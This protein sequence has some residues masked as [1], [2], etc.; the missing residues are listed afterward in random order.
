MD[1]PAVLEAPPAA[2]LAG[3]CRCTYVARFDGGRYDLVPDGCIDLLWRSDGSLVVCGPETAGWSF[4]VPAG[5]TTAG[6]RLEP[7]VAPALL[8]ASA[9]DL[10][11][12]QV[13]VEA[14]LPGPAARR[15][16]DRLGHA[17]GPDAQR[18]VLVDVVRRLADDLD[19]VGAL[20]RV[21]DAIAGADAGTDLA[22]VA[23]DLG[24]SRRQ[25]HRSAQR[26]VGYGPSM[27]RRIVRVQRALRLVDRG[28]VASLGTIAS[29]A[30]F[31]DHAH[32][33]RE[34]RTIARMT[35]SRAALPRARG[36]TR[37]PTVRV[38]A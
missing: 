19:D 6:V 37:P 27:F 18:R 29:M 31:A 17:P 16:V 38:A 14:L 24:M 23:R 3:V 11:D 32:M 34:F 26:L 33:T 1:R 10:R 36:G 15:V 21:P 35:P 4:D 28:S 30:G 12:R 13:A 20:R 8:R 22:A 7:G 9:D 25:L 5:S 2:D